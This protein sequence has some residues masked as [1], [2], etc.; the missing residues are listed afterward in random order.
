MLTADP[1]LWHRCCPG[2]LGHF[3]PHR[4]IAINRDFLINDRFTIK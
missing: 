3:L 4:G 2:R 1:N